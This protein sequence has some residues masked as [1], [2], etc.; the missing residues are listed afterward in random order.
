VTL[1]DVLV[2]LAL[3]IGLAGIIVPVLPGTLLMLAALLVWA[4]SVG[5]S[6]GWVVVSIAGSFL[7]VGTLVKY[8]VPGRRMQAAGVPSSTLWIGAGLGIVGFFVIPVVGLL[9][10]FV[11]GV[12]LAEHRRVGAA[13]AW[14][15][16]KA[17]LTA[18]GLGILIELAAGV[19]ATGTWV[20]GVIAT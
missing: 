6:A 19:L 17:A 14:P 9:V 15:S 10:G 20:V 1:T 13:G 7:A 4:L 11:A 16:T 3:L 8:V 5:T 2:G 12:Y 18:V